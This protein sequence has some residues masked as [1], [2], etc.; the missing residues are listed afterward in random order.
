LGM[1]SV[2]PSFRFPDDYNFWQWHWVHSLN[3][4]IYFC[5]VRFKM[6]PFYF[7]YYCYS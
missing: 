3:M 1:T 2:F 4:S 6:V 5:L 7:V